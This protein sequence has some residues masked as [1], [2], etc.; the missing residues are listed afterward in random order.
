MISIDFVQKGT[1]LSTRLIKKMSPHSSHIITVV[2]LPGTTIVLIRGD[3]L[4][5]TVVC[6]H[7]LNNWCPD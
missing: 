1:M 2:I 7:F 4:F 3:V 6:M 5:S